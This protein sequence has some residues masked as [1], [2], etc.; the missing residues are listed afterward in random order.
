[1]ERL[2]QG[3]KLKQW[4][5]FLLFAMVQVVAFAQDGGETSTK[6]VTTTSKT[7]VMIQPWMWVVG[8]AVLLIILIALLRGGS[9]TTSTSEKVIVTKSDD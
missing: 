7:E 1:M 6:T 4:Y 5:L 8:G 2:L 9:S 3:T